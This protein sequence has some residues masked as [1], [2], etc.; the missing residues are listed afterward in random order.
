MPLLFTLASGLF[1]GLS[2]LVKNPFV[3]KMLLFS[4]FL[5]VITASVTY[6]QSLVSPYISSNPYLT[7]GAYFGILDGI[8]LYLTIVLAGFGVKQILAFMRS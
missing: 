5:G 2:L 3:Q 6:L 8:S 4:F 7:V 1:S